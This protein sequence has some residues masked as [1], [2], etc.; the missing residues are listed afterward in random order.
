MKQIVINLH[1]GKR[2]EKEEKDET[3][4]KGIIKKLAKRKKQKPTEPKISKSL[5][6]LV[7]QGLS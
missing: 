1:M 4:E 3:P 5:N 6:E 7:Q 2:D